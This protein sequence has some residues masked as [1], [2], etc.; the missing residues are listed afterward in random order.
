[1][2]NVSAG[3]NITQLSV[4]DPL[5]L[6]EIILNTQEPLRVKDQIKCD[7]ISW[8]LDK[9]NEELG[10]EQLQF[11]CGKNLYTKDP[12]W[13]STCLTKQATFADFLKHIQMRNPTR[14]WYFD[15]KYLCQWFTE[16]TSLMGKID[17]SSLGFPELSSN[18][19][20]IWIGSKGA[21]TPCHVDTYGCNIILQI[22]GRKQWFLF[23]PEQNLK[24]TRIP[25]EESSIYSKLNFFSPNEEKFK[26][27]SHCHKVVLSPGEVLI[28][29]NKWW[30]YVENLDTAISINAWIPLPQDEYERIKEGVAAIFTGKM[31][32]NNTALQKII[33][34]PNMATEMI[35]SED[36]LKIIALSTEK[37][38]PKNKFSRTEVEKIKLKM[39]TK[40][41]D[42]LMFKYCNIIKIPVLTEEEFRTSLAE[43]AARFKH[44]RPRDQQKTNDTENKNLI[45]FLEVVTDDEVLDLI[46]RKLVEKI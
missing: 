39:E 32:Q 6:R 36:A 45:D 29:P 33:L 27:I 11:R 20:T 7:L 38:K 5:D 8:N 30:H 16:K 34:N 14:W 43:Q 4:T 18:D 15:Y 12:Q 13:E 9:W 35:R 2:N 41:V 25:F 22:Y 24:P 44:V 17:W 23:A 3:S 40:D 19:T 1:M 42:S 28:V 21:H 10:N 46:A 26:G 31:V 37:Y